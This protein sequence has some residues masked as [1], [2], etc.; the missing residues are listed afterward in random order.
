MRIIWNY[1]ADDTAPRR[2]PGDRKREIDNGRFGG[3]HDTFLFNDLIIYA[4][5]SG[6]TVPTTHI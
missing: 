2:A 5:I 4:M 1:A 3:R 6:K